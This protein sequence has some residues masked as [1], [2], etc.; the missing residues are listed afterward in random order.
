[1][2]HLFV[3]SIIRND[4]RPHKVT[5]LT[6]LCSFFHTSSIRHIKYLFFIVFATKHVFF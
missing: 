1:M 2:I 6:V 4:Y 5:N 3:Q